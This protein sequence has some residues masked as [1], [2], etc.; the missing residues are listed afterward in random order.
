M[1]HHV[2]KGTCGAV[3]DQP[4]MCATEGCT[5]KGMPFEACDCGDASSHKKEENKDSGGDEN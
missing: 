5:N 2:C 4:D 1:E 3:S